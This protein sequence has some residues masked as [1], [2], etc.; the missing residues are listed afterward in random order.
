VPRTNPQLSLYQ[1]EA[2]QKVGDWKMVL[3]VGFGENIICL[4]D[5]ASREWLCA[6]YK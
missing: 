5:S 3:I 4:G 1:F 2:T 6:G